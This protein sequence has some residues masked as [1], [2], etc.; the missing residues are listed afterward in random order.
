MTKENSLKYYDE[1]LNKYA[2]LQESQKQAVINNVESFLKELKE[3]GFL[4]EYKFEKIEK[5]IS[6]YKQWRE[7]ERLNTT[8]YNAIRMLDD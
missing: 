5:S 8:V 6:E 4:N 7:M 2:R 3:D 1:E